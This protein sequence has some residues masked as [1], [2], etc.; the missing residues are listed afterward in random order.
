MKLFSYLSCFC[1]VEGFALAAVAF[2]LDRRSP[3]N[4]I[5][6][7]GSFAY[8]VWALGMTFA[9]GS[10]FP[11]T[12][13]G[14]YQFSFLGSLFMPPLLV[15]LYLLLAQGSARIRRWCVAAAFAWAVFVMSD[16]V[17]NGFYYGSFR[18]GQWSNVGVPSEHWFWATFNPYIQALQVVAAISVWGYRA[19]RRSERERRQLRI[20]VP[21]LLV[22]ILVDFTAWGLEIWAGLPNAMVLTGS[23]MITVTFVVIAR[24][25]HLLPDR[26]LLERHLF[27]VVQESAF[28]LDV[29]GRIVGINEPALR[30]LRTGESDLIGRELRGLLEDPVMLDREWRLAIARKSLHRRLL[31]TMEGRTLVLTL[32]TRFDEFNDLAGAVAFVGELPGFDERASYWGITPREKQVLLLAVQDTPFT[33]IADTLG[34]SPGTVKTHLHKLCEKTG[35]ANR[36]ELFGRLLG[37]PRSVSGSK[38]TAIG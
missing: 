27:D 11:A 10:E 18:D 9:Y 20:L 32:T 1:A 37:A 23:I 15:W 33:E 21:G 35:C 7:A 12:A 31:V 16:Y 5:A 6:A 19:R 13:V 36:V 38:M 28:L 30:L 17:A 25:R 24:Y 2:A 3:V 34:I 8:A 4:R 14:F 26:P 29:H 22:T